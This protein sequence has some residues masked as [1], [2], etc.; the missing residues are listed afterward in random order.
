MKLK[1]QIEIS[2]TAAKNPEF[3]KIV[4]EKIKNK[5]NLKKD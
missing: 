5:Q 1:M 3:M 2:K 4:Q